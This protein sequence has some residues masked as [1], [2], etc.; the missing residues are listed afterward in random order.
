MHLFGLT[1]GIASG[2][3]AVA[4]RFRERHVPVVDADELAREV[5]V[6]GSPGLGAIVEAFGADVLLADGSLDRARLGDLVFSDPAK[7]AMLNAIVH[8]RIAEASARRSA[9]LAG[10]GEPLAC[11]EAALLVE[12]GLA[13]MFRPLVV[14]RA[15]P[16][17]QAM[18]IEAR[19][20]LD[21]ARA[22]ARIAAQRP[23]EEKVR[24]ADVIVDN[25]GS[26]A[27]LV[28]ESD[29]ALREVLSRLA[30]DPVRYFEAEA[31]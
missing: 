18:R 10:R 30:L 24:L 13:E 11:Y 27:D 6:L 15:S 25:D 9:D 22:K 19:D 12:N 26:L 2:K 5:V 28:R 1:G 23:L 31:T 3:S 16:E 17:V 14:V 8:P 20:G 4:R 7:R 29:R 21:Q